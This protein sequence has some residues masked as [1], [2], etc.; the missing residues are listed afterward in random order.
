MTPQAIADLLQPYIDQ[1]FKQVNGG[2]SSHPDLPH[3]CTQLGLYLELILKW[4]ARINLTAIRSPEEIVQRHFGE[5]LF[6]A[7]HL[8]K[9]K[10]LLDFGSGAGFPGIPMQLMR[11]D[12]HVTL[13][14]SKNKKAA[15]LREVVRSLDLETDI[16]AGRVETMPPS[17][18]FDTVALRA[19]DNI[20]AAVKAA[21]IRAAKCV[22][23][24]GTSRTFAGLQDFTIADPIPLP[25]SN[26]GI[27]L[28]AH[29]R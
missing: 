12:V 3:I 8:G 27:L 19:V 14:E 10:T 9:C 15:F 20:D 28:L 4:N 7:S 26:D 22:L 24:L 25:G 13:A 18:Q 1:T 11:P 23:I 29:R 2:P 17:R 6:A 21:S 5:S 16:W